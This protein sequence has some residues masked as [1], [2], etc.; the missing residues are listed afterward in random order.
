MWFRPICIAVPASIAGFACMAQS[1]DIEQFE[2]VF[3]PRLR[4]DLK[5]QMSSAFSDTLG[6]FSNTEGTAVLTFPIRSRFDVGFRLDTNARGLGDLLKKSVQVRAS[7]L[8]GS[9]RIGGRQVELGFDSLPMRQL[10]NASVGVMGIKL[11]KK[12]RVLFWSANVNVSEEDA[13]FD[14]ATPRFNGVIGQMHLK[15]LRRTFFYGAGLSYTDQLA[16]P[17]PFVGGSA[18]IGSDWSFQ[19]L[20]PAQVAV[21]FAPQKRT[22]FLAGLGLDAFRSGIEMNGARTNVNHGT[23]RTF[24]NVR[25]KAGKHVQVR[26]EIGYDLVRVVRFTEGD[27][28]PHRYPAQPGLV[29]GVGVNLLFGNSVFERIVDEVVN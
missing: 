13:T 5:Q 2:Q 4:L 20:L 8:L 25:H 11:T 24:L 17:V 12:Y 6:N 18:P 21:G 29:V 16:L 22:R 27:L 1:F 28:E 14:A 9:V 7:Q 15:G 3:R 19:Y 26:A 10:Y 23:L